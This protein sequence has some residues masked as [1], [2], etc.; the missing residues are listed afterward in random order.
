MITSDRLSPTEFNKVSIIGCGRVGMSTAF[1]LLLSGIA[2]HIT[3]VGRNKSHIMGEQLDLEHGLSFL[4]A[5]TIQATSN[6][7]DLA[8][9]DVVV[10]TAGS[11]QQPGENRLDLLKKNLAIIDSTI[12]TI[13]KYAPNAVIII[14][15]N[16]VD[17]LTYHAYQIAGL[18]KG[19]IFGSGTALDTSRFRFHLSEIFKVNP[20]SI[21]AYI[22]GEH[23]DSSFP[24]ISNASIGGQPLTTMPQFSEEK[25]RAAYQK[26][27]DA[28]Y[29]II[30]AKGATY[31]AIAVAVVDIIGKILRD[32]RN[33][34]PVSIPLH[35]QYGQHGVA[36]SVPC[37][38]GRGGVQ[39]IIETKLNWE[40][41][42][43][44]EKSA[45][46][47]KKYL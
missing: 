6:Y 11:S 42:A 20:K 10:L 15:S 3:L 5:T 30:A 26:T 24:V 46:S 28:A 43:L 38:I 16:P 47:L 8:H 22:L 44:M 31:Y 14:V 25:I 17:I 1:A 18:P 35:G 2:N 34:L 9:S 39:D 23:G 32:G 41:H 37:V 13:V 27:R 36:L 7:Q 21:H 40:E 33:I 45:A 12:P 4:K 29:Q 19:R